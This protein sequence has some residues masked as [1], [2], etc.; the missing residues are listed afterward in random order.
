[1]YT[2]KYL[3]EPIANPKSHNIYIIIDIHH[4]IINDILLS[5]FVGESVWYRGDNGCLRVYRYAVNNIRIPE[6]GRNRNN[7]YYLSL[8]LFESILTKFRLIY[9]YIYI[10][11]QEVRPIFRLLTS[12]A[13]SSEIGIL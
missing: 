5:L 1:M 8:L 4:N 12:S 11:E 3:H 9:I 2:V 6:F 7:F 13:H 10:R